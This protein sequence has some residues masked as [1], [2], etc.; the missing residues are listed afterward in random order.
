M[1]NNKILFIHICFTIYISI[2]GCH[3]PFLGIDINDPELT[4]QWSRKQK[5]NNSGL[6]NDELNKLN[7]AFQLLGVTEETPKKDVENIYKILART[8]HPDKQANKSEEEKRISKDKMTELN[9]AY[10]RIKQYHK[11]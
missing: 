5:Q 6:N 2:H 4:R 8:W 3:I 7:E 9:S 1:H 10:E 11:W